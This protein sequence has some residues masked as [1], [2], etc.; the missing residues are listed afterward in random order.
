MYL[1]NKRVQLFVQGDGN[2]LAQSV[3]SDF[4]FKEPGA[5]NALLGYDWRMRGVLT[6]KEVLSG[7][8]D[9]PVSTAVLRHLQRLGMVRA[10]HGVRSQGGRMR[11]WPLAEVLKAQI[12]LDLRA[13]TGAR[14][15]ACVDAFALQPGLM[16]ELVSDWERHIGC[17]YD[18]R[19]EIALEGQASNLLFD[20]HALSNFAEASVSAFV[21]R[22]ALGQAETPAFLL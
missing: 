1:I 7:A 2:M 19:S 4:T 10:A 9:R 12:I 13:V 11:L 8:I 15:A 5:L 16:D 6:D 22:N 21:K 17:Q 3:R 18:R 14:L 20:R